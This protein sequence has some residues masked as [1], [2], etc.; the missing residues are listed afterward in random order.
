MTSENEHI[1]SF[2]RAI[3]L[4]GTIKSTS[5][6]LVVKESQFARMR[7]RYNS[8]TKAKALLSLKTVSP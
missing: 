7:E 1:C 4:N 8:E 6:F 5:G 2:A 3:R